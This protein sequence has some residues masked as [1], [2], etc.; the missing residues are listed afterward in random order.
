MNK[1][2]I[3]LTAVTILAFVATVVYL[4]VDFNTSNKEFSVCEP[5]GKCV[6]ANADEISEG[7]G[8]GIVKEKVAICGNYTII[9]N[10]IK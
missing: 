2:S 1:I 9:K 6:E 4:I 10:N 5:N 7:N 8:C 3:I